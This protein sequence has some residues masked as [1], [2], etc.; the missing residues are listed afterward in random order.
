MRPIRAYLF[1]RTENAQWGCQVFRDLE[2]L[3]EATIKANAGKQNPVGVH[4][5]FERPDTESV[6]KLLSSQDGLVFLSSGAIGTMP[7]P[8]R[9]SQISIGSAGETLFHIALDGFGYQVEQALYEP[10]NLFQQKSQTTP[11]EINKPSGWVKSLAKLEFDLFEKL[12]A[13]GIW[14]EDTYLE[15]EIN[16]DLDTRHQVGMHRYQILEG[17]HPT[18]ETLI[19]HLRS[20]PPW[21]L[22]TSVMMLNLSVRSANVFE[23]NE[24]DSIRDIAKYGL[25]GLFKL[26]S[27]GKKSVSEISHEM[28]RLF[29]TGHPLRGN[30]EKLESNQGKD[31]IPSIIAGFE[32]VGQM[33]TQTERSIW[34]SR[35]G[36]NRESIRLEEI[37]DQIGVTRERVRQILVKIYE[38]IQIHPFWNELSRRVFEHL[39]G[40][41]EV[42]YL[43]TLPAIDSWFDGVDQITPA[44]R[45]VTDK[46]P[47]LRFHILSWN[48]APVISR[49]NEVQWREAL[50]GAKRMIEA[51]ADQNLME[52]EAISHITSVLIDKGEEMQEALLEEVDRF[53]IWSVQPDG[54]RILSGFGK[55]L[56]KIVLSVLETSGTPLHVK[57]IQKRILANSA[58]NIKHLEYIRRAAS[59]VGLL[60]GRSIYGLL[61]HCPLNC[62]QMQAICAEVEDIISGGMPSKQWHSGEF[63]EELLSR[64]FSYDGKLTKFTINIA[65]SNSPVLIYL[66]RMTWGVRG[67]WKENPNYRLGLKQAIVSLLEQEGKPMNTMEIRSRLIEQRGINNNFQ[68]LA[69]SPLVKLGPGVWGLEGRDMDMEYIH[70]MVHTLINELSSSQE[71]MHTSEVATFLNLNSEDEVFALMSI[72]QKD[73][74]RMDAGQYCYLNSWGKSRRISL[75]KAATITLKN[76]P[77]GLLK[78]DIQRYVARIAK[79]KVGHQQLSAILQN[80]DAVYDAGSSLWKYEGSI[81][82]DCDTD[83]MAEGFSD[84][85]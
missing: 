68:I 35:I 3:L 16:L 80:I 71:G 8:I 18:P 30:S 59:E 70:E 73:G 37:G 25:T 33:L 17:E 76:H 51:I 36:L 40:R 81:N 7:S 66:G 43:N 85:T 44:I 62:Q 56:P 82:G 6:A 34:E 45:E 27:L 47:D 69:S 60:Y 48:D 31:T 49:L 84:E 58:S 38:R 64:G 83:E 77:H 75:S 23:D 55:A 74:L 1:H 57:E 21:L 14:N 79:R 9:A 12:S 24:I 41:R 50:Q 22:N 67:Q 42:L 52:P 26:R 53:C 28:V 20:A 5:G 2:P 29:T 78:T 46:I 4:V 39:Q 32:K 13:A 15:C 19:D 63:Y 65:L 61:K 54:S 10:L 11:S 72:A